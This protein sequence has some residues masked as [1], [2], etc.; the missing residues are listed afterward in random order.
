MLIALRWALHIPGADENIKDA[1]TSGVT[2]R[3]EK[4]A[5]QKALWPWLERV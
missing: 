3:E 2:V 5:R 4:A 1:A